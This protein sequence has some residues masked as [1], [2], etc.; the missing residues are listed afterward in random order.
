MKKALVLIVL[1]VTTA[2]VYSQ[3]LSFGPKLGFNLAKIPTKVES[4]LVSNLTADNILGVNVG[5]FA[6]IKIKKIF[7]Q[8]EALFSMKGGKFTYDY[9]QIDPANPTQTLT[10]GVSQTIKV[11]N[12]DIPILIGYQVGGK[13]LN[14]RLF[15]GPIGSYVLN[16]KVTLTKDGASI[17]NSTSFNMK[18]AVWSVAAGFGADI[19]KFSLDLRY[20]RALNNV[21]WNSAFKQ[22][23]TNLVFS[24]GYKI[25]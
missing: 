3:M 9:T 25:L 19:F 17:T 13:K 5:L 16:E 14:A 2:T 10:D 18:D 23:P 11:N 4:D 15:A 7:I 20:E 12:L 1:L 8:P 24:L 22:H 21:S 6:R